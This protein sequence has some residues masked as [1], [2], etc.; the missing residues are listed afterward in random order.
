LSAF[1]FDNNSSPNYPKSIWSFLEKPPSAGAKGSRRQL[2]IDSWNKHGVL[3]HQN[4]KGKELE[5]SELLDQRMAMLSDVK[6]VVS[7]MD[8]GLMELS[9]A[10]LEYYEN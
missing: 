3:S 4:Q 10:V 2:L 5:T 9:D 8:N 6:S 7:E 1:L